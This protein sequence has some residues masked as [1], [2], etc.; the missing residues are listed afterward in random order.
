ML[1]IRYL[2]FTTLATYTNG[3][4]AVSHSQFDEYL[5]SFV[6]IFLAAAKYDV[7]IS[8][9]CPGLDYIVVE[10]TAAAQACVELLRRKN[11]GVAT[12]MI[13]VSSYLVY[14]VL[15]ILYFL[16]MISSLSSS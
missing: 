2:L 7:A 4:I 3:I 10:T 6:C 16:F 1:Y 15:P 8:T 14:F 13:M 11:L 9:A 12:F 5:L